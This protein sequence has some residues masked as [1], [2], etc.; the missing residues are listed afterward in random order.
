MV[1]ADKPKRSNTLKERTLFKYMHCKQSL[2]FLG[3]MKI[4]DKALEGW[5][6]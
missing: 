5:V 6:L 1:K 3:R 2:F 4:V